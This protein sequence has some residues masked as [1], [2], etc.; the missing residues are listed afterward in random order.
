MER[1]CKL[2]TKNP[3]VEIELTYQ[4]SWHDHSFDHAFGTEIQGGY[5]I[6][7]W[8]V[9]IS[10]FVVGWKT[11]TLDCLEVPIPLYDTLEEYCEADLINNPPQEEN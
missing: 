5:E 7:S 3:N 6:D 8:S 4:C 10:K 9:S 11:V 2:N 1:T